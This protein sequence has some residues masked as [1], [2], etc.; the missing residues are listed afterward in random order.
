MKF[1]TFK[2]ERWQSMWENEV[3]LNLSDSGI[4]PLTLNELIEGEGVE[5]LLETRL[6]YTQTNG[7]HELRE[8]IA[9]LYP[10]ARV[11]N[12][13]VT[14]GTAEANLLAALTLIQADDEVIV[15]LP[16]YM[17]LW[18]VF[19]ALGARTGAWNLAPDLGAGRWHDRLD[20]LDEMVTPRTRMIALCNPNNPS[21]H[22]L[23]ADELDRVA[24]IADRVGAWVLVDEIYQGME[25]SSGPTPTMWGRYDKVIVT[26]S[27][28]K[29]YGLPGL[30]IGWILG[31]ES[32]VAEC[33]RTHDYTTIAMGALSDRLACGVLETARRDRVMVRTQEILKRNLPV[34]VQ[35]VSKTENLKP[36]LPKAGA[37]LM[38]SYEERINSSELAER[39]RIEKSL[40]VV[41]GDHF[42]MDGWIRI[43]FGDETNHIEEGLSRIDALLNEVRHAGT[44]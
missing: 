32:T 20:E 16:N 19:Q 6:A 43:G 12:V 10:G 35:H 36:I 21:G 3:E 17:Q 2:M 25:I 1:D 37:F 34:V 24:A 11:E 23:G 30:R 5:S 8:R 39:L 13:E 9:A 18:G 40:L 14:N 26:N 41:P 27:L 31:P 38:L 15:Q 29:S 22:V 28:S 4:S 44:S 7:T 33:W 42:G